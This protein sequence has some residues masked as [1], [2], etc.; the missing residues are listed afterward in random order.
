MELL[1]GSKDGADEKVP[2]THNA[3]DA[4]QG[5]RSMMAWLREAGLEK[6]KM[7]GWL[8][9]ELEVRIAEAWN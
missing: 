1:S 2:G 6:K 8:V 7:K 4:V 5:W 9:E 3:C